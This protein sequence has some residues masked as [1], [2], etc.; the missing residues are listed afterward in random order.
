MVFKSTIKTISL[1]FLTSS[2]LLIVST[3]VCLAQARLANPYTERVND[4]GTAGVLVNGIPNFQKTTDV[5]FRGGRPTQQGLDYLKK[6]GFK[7]IINIENN[8]DAV[9]AE[10]KYTQ[11]IGLQ[12]FS[13]PLP[14][15]K[16]PND[17]QVMKIIEALKNPVYHPVIIHCHYGKDR[18]GLIIGLYRVLVQGWKPQDAYAEMI[19]YGFH[20]EYKALDNY[21]RAKTRMR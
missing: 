9:N 6:A 7:T 10:Y 12:M 21:Y 3:N 8:M 19:K 14:W 5:I 1:A 4:E 16:T 18:T 15:T 11:K 17:A 20:T 13:S 2:T